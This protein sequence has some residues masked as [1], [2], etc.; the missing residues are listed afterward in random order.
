MSGS[1]PADAEPATSQ[2]A[3]APDPK[4]GLS[5]SRRIAVWALVVLG[6]IVMLVS[7]LT[8]W[9]DR[10]V[11]DNNSWRHASEQLIQ[12]PEIQ[13]T[14]SVYLVN[15]IYDNV[16][17][18]A[19]LQERLPP[20]LDRLAPGIAG[21]LRGASTNAVKTL[22]QRPK[23]QQLFVNASSAA[24]QKLVNVLED[25]TGH[26][27]TTG[28]GTVTVDLRTLLIQVAHKLGLSGKR[29]EQLPP[30]TGQFVVM[31]SSQLDTLQTTVK[32]INVLS[33]FLLIAVLAIFALAIFL[34]RGV[35]RATLRNIAFSFI[36]VGLLILLVRRFSGNYVVSALTSPEY[37]GSVRRVFVI[38]SAILGDIGRATVFYGVIALLGALLAGPTRLAIRIR[39]WIAPM[40]VE[41]PGVAWGILGALFLL[42]VLW[43]PTHALGTWWGILLLAGLL[44]LGFEALRR[45]MVREFP[46]GSL[47]TAGANGNGASPLDRSPAE[48]LAKLNA[49]HAAGQ[50]SD[51]EFARAK[52]VVLA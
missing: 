24:Q 50:I 14:L 19:A 22:L 12:D 4:P 6:S 42:L 23:F 8:T 34:A 32:A 43:Q 30:G 29:L 49:L 38:G 41:Q 13:D 35:R 18:S 15:Q 47:A 21:A 51:E 9:V 36:V 44:A 40:V 11:L 48:E 1:T 33:V 26:G 2:G 7:I 31:K 5:K 10:Q 52:Q 27:I 39:R 25:K 45:A 37:E 16:D 3:K 17:V 46:P 20:Q 28:N